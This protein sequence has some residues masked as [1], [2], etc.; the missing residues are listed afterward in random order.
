MK[1]L[2]TCIVGCYVVACAGLL[3]DTKR[4]P[5]GQRIAEWGLALATLGLVAIC[6]RILLGAVWGV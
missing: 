3:L 6:L 5:T 1:L 2:I 4:H